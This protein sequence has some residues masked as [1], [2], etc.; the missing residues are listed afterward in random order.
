MSTQSDALVVG[1]AEVDIT[2][3]W[4]MHLVGMGRD[5]VAHDGRNFA[6]SARDEPASETHDPIM[7]QATYLRVGSQAVIIISADLVYTAALDALRAAVAQ[8]CRLPVQAVIYAATHN[9]NGPAG[10]ERYAALLCERAAECALR[11]MASAVTAVV[12]HAQGHFDRLMHDRAEPW[13]PVDGAIDVLRFRACDGENTIAMW[14]SYGCHPCSL[15]WD[16]NQ[17]SADYPGAIRRHVAQAQVQ[18]QE[19]PF[20]VSFLSGCT[21]NIQPIGMMR[22]SS[23]PEMYLG[24]PKG[25]YE[26][27]ERLGQCVAEAGLRALSEQSRPLATDGYSLTYHSASLPVQLLLDKAGLQQ[28]RTSLGETLAQKV[29]GASPESSIND[30]LSRLLGDWVDELLPQADA[31]CPTHAVSSAIFA[32]GGLAVIFTPL[33]LAWQIGKRIRERSPFT[34]TLMSTTSL[35]YESYLTEPKF[36]ALPIDKRPYEAHGLMATAG[37]SYTPASADV[38]EEVVV[39]GLSKA[40][41]T[42]RRVAT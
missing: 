29:A 15:S 40:A 13:G 38:F 25:D 11:A 31:V 30:D 37:Y 26:M 33:E 5:F 24:V 21:G 14:W 7:L 20:P 39:D 16:F 22:F 9:H 4:P 34:T 19:A 1:A 42:V 27:V 36:Y 23:P 17:F 2:P 10:T 18:V 35:G 3:S 6:Y 28:L 32:I 41:N 8:A 12:E